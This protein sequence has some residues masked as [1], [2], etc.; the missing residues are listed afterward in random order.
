MDGDF[1]PRPAGPD[2]AAE[3]LD[4]VWSSSTGPFRG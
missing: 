3:I 4:D 1:A 2:E